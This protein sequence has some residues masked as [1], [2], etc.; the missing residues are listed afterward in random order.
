MS[1]EELRKH[2][3]SELSIVAN[4]PPY[5]EIFQ[6][7]SLKDLFFLDFC[8]APKV[9]NIRLF[10]PNYFSDEEYSQKMSQKSNGFTEFE[11][12]VMDINHQFYDLVASRKLEDEYYLQ[13]IKQT[14]IF[15]VLSSVKLVIDN[16]ERYPSRQV[17]D[18]IIFEMVESQGRE[19]L[20][21]LD[22][23][24]YNDLKNA[25]LTEIVNNNTNSWE[26]LHVAFFDG[27]TDATRWSIIKTKL[28]QLL[29]SGLSDETH[30]SY[31]GIAE[32]LKEYISG[33]SDS[34]LETIIEE[35]R[36]PDGSALKKWESSKANAHRFCSKYK[37]SKAQFKKCFGL[38]LKSSDINNVKMEKDG[39]IWDI[40]NEYPK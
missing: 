8:K 21:L 24:R 32:R 11:L 16:I 1:S 13:D 19:I 38:E 39:T 35:K 23:L 20:T 37:L 15:K 18:R 29:K 5:M 34:D 12:Y 2:F 26:L 36:L 31:R 40:L 30:K 33:A 9:P 4:Q 10:R 6:D 25:V 27:Q 7:R 3:E 22:D 17:D 28:N 14:N